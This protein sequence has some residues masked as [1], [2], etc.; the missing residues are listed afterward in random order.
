[1]NNIRYKPLPNELFFVRVPL[2]ATYSEVEI[3]HLGLPI[4]VINGRPDHSTYNTMTAVYLPLDKIID[5]YISGYPIKLIDHNS[6]DRIY[7]ILDQYVRGLNE[8]DNY[9]LNVAGVVEERLYDIEKFAAEIFDINKVAILSKLIKFRNGYDAKVDTMPLFDNNNGYFNN[10]R[11]YQEQPVINNNHMS[12]YQTM[13]S[14]SFVNQQFGPPEFGGYPNDDGHYGNNG[15]A[16]DALRFNPGKKELSNKTYI[17]NNLPE[18]NFSKA[19]RERTQI[20]INQ[21]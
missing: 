9:E 2:I 15:S 17:N 18:I 4:N 13:L 20:R 21:K 16:R 19:T 12:G 11:Y 10:N 3:N 8:N 5:I 14:N 7:T 6:L 1:M